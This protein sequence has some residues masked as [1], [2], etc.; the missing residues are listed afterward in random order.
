MMVQFEF[1]DGEQMIVKFKSNDD[2]DEFIA[3]VD[4]ADDEGNK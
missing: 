2:Y 1:E 3:G 4:L